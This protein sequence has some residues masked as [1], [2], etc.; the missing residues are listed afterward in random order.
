MANQPEQT[1]QTAPE[2]ARAITRL[3]ASQRLAALATEGGGR[4]Y[5]NLVAFVASDDL[6]KIFL[7]TPRDTRKYANLAA[8]PHASLLVDNRADAGQDPDQ[9]MAVTALGTAAEVSE[10]RQDAVRRLYLKRHPALSRFIAD[11]EVALL[12][13]RVSRYI[14]VLGLDRVFNLAVSG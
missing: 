2:A 6:T 12:S 3:L 10:D 11:P 8:N 1:L 7:A 14:C 9:G 4:P 13:L 5:V